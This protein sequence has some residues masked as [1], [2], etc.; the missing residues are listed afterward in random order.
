MIKLN[1][2]VIPITWKELRDGYIYLLTENL[3]LPDYFIN[4][5]NLGNIGDCT[6]NNCYIKKINTL[7]KFDYNTY[8]AL[9]TKINKDFISMNICQDH[10][11]PLIQRQ[12]FDN[13]D[14]EIAY[15]MSATSL[16]KL[17]KVDFANLIFSRLD[18]KFEINKENN[19]FFYKVYN[20]LRNNTFLKINFSY[21]SEKFKNY[22][23]AD[24]ETISNIKDLQLALRYVIENEVLYNSKRNQALDLVIREFVN[25]YNDYKYFYI[26]TTDESELSKDLY[27]LNSN[28]N[29]LARNL[30]LD[31]ISQLKNK[32]FLS[33]NEEAYDIILNN[34]ETNKQN[35][36]AD[37]KHS[38]SDIV[39]VALKYLPNQNSL[40]THGFINCNSIKTY[41]YLLHNLFPKYEIIFEQ[42]SDPYV[43]KRFIAKLSFDDY[44]KLYL[45]FDNILESDIYDETE[46][47]IVKDATAFWSNDIGS[48]YYFFDEAIRVSKLL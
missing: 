4:L 19:N 20:Y 16:V 10:N 2:N 32:D 23:N 33:I 40:L 11:L 7:E 36:L 38:S 27:K 31:I 29:K 14:N 47:S 41:F 21:K 18:S 34:Y 26:E 5:C 46:S 13:T 22:S 48:P 39:Y 25:I 17:K 9:T 8:K 12:V 45:F 6:E 28:F 42:I 1:N 3:T 35:F 30:F 15:L 37:S 43:G 24:L 44:L